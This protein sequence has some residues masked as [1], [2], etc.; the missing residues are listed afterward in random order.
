MSDLDALELLVK[1]IKKSKLIVNGEV[2]GNQE[3]YEIITYVD[4]IAVEDE[5][6]VEIVSVPR[7]DKSDG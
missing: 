1:A 6:G 7:L 3:T 4:V 2:T 5:N